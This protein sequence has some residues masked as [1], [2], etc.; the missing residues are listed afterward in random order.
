MKMLAVAAT[1]AA[2]T[3]SQALAQPGAPPSYSGKPGPVCLYPYMIDHTHVVDPRTILFYMR[4]GK[5]WRNTMKTGC[6]GLMFHGFV[7]V[8]HFDELCSNMQSIRVIKT[9]EV[10]VLGTFTPER[11]PRPH[12]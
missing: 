2:L 1:I 5:V 7:Y 11:V 10:C 12:I 3:V 4:D 8:T 6:R 9:G